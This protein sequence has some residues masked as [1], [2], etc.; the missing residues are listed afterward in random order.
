MEEFGKLADA[1]PDPSSWVGLELFDVACVP[2]PG[3]RPLPRNQEMVLEVLLSKALL[4]IR[5]G[6]EQVFFGTGSQHR[7]QGGSNVG[8]GGGG[9]GGGLSGGA[10]ARP[11]RMVRLLSR[12]ISGGNIRTASVLQVFSFIR[13]AFIR[14]RNF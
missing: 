5:S 8:G 6:L 1:A 14:R 11:E 13:G 4:R 7:H 9:S 12:C 3:A 2:S 10:A